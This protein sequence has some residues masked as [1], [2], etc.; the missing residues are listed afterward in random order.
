VQH[1]PQNRASFVYLFGEYGRCHLKE[2]YERAKCGKEVR[3]KI[4]RKI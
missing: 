2:K 4:E 1:G 3:G